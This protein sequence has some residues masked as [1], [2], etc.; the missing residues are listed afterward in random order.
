MN[1]AWEENIQI[2][3]VKRLW[4]IFIVFHSERLWF[5]FIVF[6]SYLFIYFKITGYLFQITLVTYFKTTLVIW[7]WYLI[8]F[9]NVFSQAGVTLVIR[10]ITVTVWFEL[11]QFQWPLK[12][13]LCRKETHGLGEQTCGCQGGGGGSGVRWKLGVKRCKLLPSEWISNEILLCSTGNYIQSL[14]MEPDGG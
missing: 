2:L 4:F 13:T 8:F 6:H 11:T 1:N 14:V 12:G 9:L 3:T 5:I 10:G 7:S